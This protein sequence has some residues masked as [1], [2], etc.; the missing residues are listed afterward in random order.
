MFNLYW[1]VLLKTGKLKFYYLPI[2]SRFTSPSLKHRQELVGTLTWLEFRES[3]PQ[4]R[5]CRDSD[6]F[7]ICSPFSIETTIFKIFFLLNKLIGGVCVWWSQIIFPFIRLFCSNQQSRQTKSAWYGK[8]FI[9]S[10]LTPS[11]KRP[12]EVIWSCG[13]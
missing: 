1:M 13:R 12:N 2:Y 6:F 9:S 10:I 3:S 11:C 7:R 8:S 4:K 5:F